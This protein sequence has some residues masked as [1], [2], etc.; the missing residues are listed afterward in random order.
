MK[1]GKYNG[2]EINRT[3]VTLFQHL[4]WESWFDDLNKQ[5]QCTVIKIAMLQ[6]KE[7]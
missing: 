1:S 4:P 2:Q 7:N 6:S 5:S 3:Q